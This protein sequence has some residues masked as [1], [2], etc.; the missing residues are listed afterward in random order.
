MWC[1]V[2]S[3]PGLAGGGFTGENGGGKAGKKGAGKG[4]KNAKGT[5][6]GGG[7]PGT[8]GGVAGDHPN[9]PDAVIRNYLEGLLWVL[10]TYLNGRPLDFHYRCLSLANPQ[11]AAHVS[12]RSVQQYL[13]NA[14]RTTSTSTLANLHGP[15][16]RSNPKTGSP[17]CPA[18]AC[19]AMLPCQA[20]EGLLP[21]WGCLADLVSP[22]AELLGAVVRVERDEGWDG[23][24]T[25]LIGM[26][27]TSSEFEYTRVF[28]HS[29]RVD[30]S[31]DHDSRVV[32]LCWRRSC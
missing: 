19:L 32:W 13:R 22:D 1:L 10:D 30:S 2:V 26:R 18:A 4:G 24:E 5:A 3:V 31:A 8:S 21:H 29:R 7:A 25:L 28:Y 9:A 15:V 11:L 27:T 20:V 12:G 6:G 17:L 14:V 16:N 23:G